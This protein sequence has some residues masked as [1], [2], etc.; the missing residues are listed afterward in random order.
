MLQRIRRFGV[1]QTAKVVAVIY[2]LMGVVFV[3]IILIVSMYA[4]DKGGPGAGF[5]LLMPL[6]YGLLGFVFTAISCAVY[7]IVA[8]LVGG[9]EVELDDSAAAG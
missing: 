5:V 8:G 4:P 3:P 6:L 9:V 1:L 2:T 7:N